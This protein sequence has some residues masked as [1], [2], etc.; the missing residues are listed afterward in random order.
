MAISEATVE[1]VRSAA[2][3]REVVGHYRDLRRQGAEWVCC[4]P[5][6]DE[7][8]PSFHVNE[9]KNTYY[10]HGSCHEGGDA[11]KFIMKLE[12]LDF[13]GAVKFL[14]RM[15]NIVVEETEDKRTDEQRKAYERRETA[16]AVLADVQRF[17]EDE[18]RAD[19]PQ[20]A[21]ARRYA[22]DRWPREFCEEYG[23]GY[24]SG[25]ANALIGHIRSKGHNA[26]VLKDLGL[27][28]LDD[29]REPKCQ[30]KH[31]VTIPIRDMQK[32]VTGF[33]CR[34]LSTNPEIPKYKNSSNSLVYQKDRTLFGAD[35]ASNAVH[36]A[37]ALF[38]V[39]GAPDVLRCQ[40]LGIDNVM[41]PLG[42]SLTEEQ[43][44][45]LKRVCDTLVFIP[46][47]DPPKGGNAHGAGDIAVMKNGR[48]AIEAGFNVRV[49]ELPRQYA[50][51]D[52]KQQLK[53]D[54]DSFITSKEVFADLPETD[55]IIWYDRLVY[56]KTDDNT[57]AVSA[58]IT[59]VCSL[60]A[61]H[62][63]TP[64]TSLYLPK[65]TQLHGNKAVWR[66]TLADAVN[67]MQ[68]TAEKEKPKDAS[69]ESKSGLGKYGF[70]IADNCYCKMT[71]DDDV[72]RLSNFLM[73]PLYYIP[74]NSSAVFIF[75]LVNDEGRERI[76]SFDPDELVNIAPFRRKL[77]INGN[78]IWRAK[79]DDLM[80]VQEYI[81]K[82]AP[83]AQ[84][85]RTMGWQKEGV[86]A[87]GN[88]VVYG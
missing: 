32:R 55:F 45:T 63:D 34:T 15:F 30:M 67:H 53:A 84:M 22:F 64:K 41:A 5:F 33:T 29:H 8:T 77:I 58:A 38:L 40:S 36:K 13:I 46:D 35:R 17:F 24:A 69:P 82:D 80:K 60:L 25:D 44:K 39:E 57:A 47:S 37:G 88:G 9:R 51:P 78:F 31:R 2:D 79:L 27:V 1:R 19:T 62:G 4:C 3:I 73:L 83:T 48:A 56:P 7:K 10:C 68:R 87:W 49:R 21:Q 26:E 76:V 72:V 71:K 74:D 70:F 85:V 86:Y 18:L 50:D 6:H 28:F 81:L 75:R 52:K 65:L 54:P 59:D 20:A 42:S 14:A 11:V 23:I 16:F 12:G 66:Q 61:A 43:L